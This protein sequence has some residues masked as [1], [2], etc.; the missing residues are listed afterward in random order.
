MREGEGGYAGTT[1]TSSGNDV[2]EKMLLC[3]NF[4]VLRYLMKF[5]VLLV[6]VFMTIRGKRSYLVLSS[7]LA[8]LMKRVALKVNMTKHEN[9]AIQKRHI[10]AI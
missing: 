8:A 9:E 6:S 10:L 1:R 3:P 7:K 4:N 5:L 2:R